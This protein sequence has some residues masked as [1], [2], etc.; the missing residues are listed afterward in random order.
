VLFYLLLPIILVHGFRSFT[1]VYRF[2][3]KQTS[4]PWLKRYLKRDEILRDIVACDTVLRDA[5]GLFGV[6]SFI[7]S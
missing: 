3:V 2:M 5:L 1:T 4:R 7:Y 6:R